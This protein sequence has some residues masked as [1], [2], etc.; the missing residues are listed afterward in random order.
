M[1][2]QQSKTL[3]KLVAHLEKIGALNAIN[4]IIYDRATIHRYLKANDY[5]I[6]NARNQ[7]IFFLKWREQEQVDKLIVSSSFLISKRNMSL[8]SIQTSK[9]TF[10]MGS[11]RRTNM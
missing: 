8:K 3:D 10:L 7:F 9:N 2:E 6:K 1:T 11:I 5:D 4:K